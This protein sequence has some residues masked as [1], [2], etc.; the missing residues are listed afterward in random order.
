VDDGSPDGT[1][2]LVKDHG[3]F[4]SRVHLLERSGKQ[5]LGSA[6][7]AGFRWALASDYELIFEMD[8]DFS[9]DPKYIPVMR[10]A[11]KQA[12]LVIGSRYLTGVNV[13]NWPMQRLLLS[14]FANK[15]AKFVTGLP[16]QDCTG[17]FKCFRRSALQLINL[18]R[19]AA[20]GYSFQIE[21]NYKLWKKGA[22]LKEIPIVFVDRLMGVSKMS[23]KIISEALYLVIRL[24]LARD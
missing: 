6:Y 4:G 19:I 24:K 16:I 22:T 13:V 7:V 8:A 9:H 2:Q 5:G 17:G 1:A 18:D 11:A 20:G 14:W 23:G 15:Y 10:A 12:D 21:M 3:E